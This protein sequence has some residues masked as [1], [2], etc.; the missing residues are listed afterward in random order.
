MPDTSLHL[1]E[2]VELAYALTARVAENIGAR[3]LAIKGR[4]S[5]AHD[6]RAP[7]TSGDADFLVEPA[8]VDDL[9]AALCDVGWLK[10]PEAPVPSPFGSHSVTLYHPS[11]PNELDIH[12]WFPGFLADPADVF[13]A[14]WVS[15]TFIV[16]ADAAVPATDLYGSALIM[17]LHALRTPSD[18]RNARE[19]RELVTRLSAR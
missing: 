13:D 15:H 10:A 17:A 12:G 9:V 18:P 7:W 2:G 5:E 3:A 4:V 19:L 14:L 1:A 16:A 8:R 6:L 11:W